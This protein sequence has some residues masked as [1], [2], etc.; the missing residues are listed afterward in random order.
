MSEINLLAQDRLLEKT[1]HETQDEWKPGFWEIL[2]IKTVVAILM[3]AVPL[4]GIVLLLRL[5]SPTDLPEILVQI[6]LGGW[7]LITIWAWIMALAT[8]FP[9]KESSVQS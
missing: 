9:P 7:I 5:M 6:F 8:P 1:Q 2:Y 4:L 3:I